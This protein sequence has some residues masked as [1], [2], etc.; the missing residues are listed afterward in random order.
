MCVLIPTT[1]LKHTRPTF[2]VQSISLDSFP[3][4]ET[5][6]AVS[7][8]KGIG[9]LIITHKKPYRPASSETIFC[10]VKDKIAAIGINFS[11]SYLP[12]FIL[13]LSLYILTISTYNTCESP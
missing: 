1:N 5:L 13:P 6:C 7:C 8:T 4:N 3:D 2:K 12:I 10:W 11:C 9:P